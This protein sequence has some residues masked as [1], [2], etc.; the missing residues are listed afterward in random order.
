MLFR[1]AMVEITEVNIAP[2]WGLF[3]GA[4]GTVMDIIFRQ[5]KIQTRDT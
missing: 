3:N 4:I 5:E 2:R 1:D